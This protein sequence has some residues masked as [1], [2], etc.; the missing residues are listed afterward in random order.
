MAGNV[1][2]PQHS[3]ADRSETEE[4]MEIADIPSMPKWL[5]VLG[6]PVCLVNSALII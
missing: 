6:T 1:V 4:N 5:G 3:W 2:D